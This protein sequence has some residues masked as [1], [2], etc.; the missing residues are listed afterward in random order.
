MAWG[1]SKKNSEGKYSRNPSSHENFMR[2]KYP[3]LSLA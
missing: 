2:M 1:G 3:D